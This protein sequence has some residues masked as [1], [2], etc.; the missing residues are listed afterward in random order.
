MLQTAIKLQHSL[1]WKLINITDP[2]F[3][4]YLSELTIVF[5]ILSFVIF[6]ISFL[7]ESDGMHCYFA[8]RWFVCQFKREVMKKN[9]DGYHDVLLLWESIW[10]CNAMRQRL[11]DQKRK[12]DSSCE[13]LTPPCGEIASDTSTSS[14]SDYDEDDSESPQVIPVFHTKEPDTVRQEFMQTRLIIA[15]GNQAYGPVKEIDETK[16]LEIKLDKIKLD[17]Q[18]TETSKQHQPN[19]ATTDGAGVSSSDVNACHYRHLMHTPRLTDTQLYVLCICLAIIRRERDLI[20]T[21]QYSN[22]DILKVFLLV[23][24]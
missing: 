10:T 3:A 19:Q 2:I 23:C 22:A 24:C 20:L 1:L 17:E 14:S 8:F 21:H 4:Q 15:N 12:N 5:V 7:G 6:I 9:D 18:Q 11:L 13:S 16:Q